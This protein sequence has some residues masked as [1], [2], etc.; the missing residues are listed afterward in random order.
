MPRENKFNLQWLKSKNNKIKSTYLHLDKCNIGRSRALI[1]F[2]VP[3]MTSRRSQL[4]LIKDIKNYFAKRLQNLKVNIQYFSVIEL[5]LQKWNPHL[6]FQIWYEEENDGRIEKAYY[7]T[8]KQFSLAQKRC[9]YTQESKGILNP[10][11]SFNYIIKEFDNTILSDKD[12]LDLDLAR[13]KLKQ[14]E[15][16]N[17]QFF[18]R[19]R[20]LHPHLLYKKLKQKYKLEYMTV[21]KLMNGYAIRLTGLKLMKAR[22]NRNFPYVIFKGGAIQIDYIKIY[23]LALLTLFYMYSYIYLSSQKSIYYN[24]RNNSYFYK[25]INTY[26]R[27]IIKKTSNSPPFKIGQRFNSHFRN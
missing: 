20:L 19:S 5:G 27:R 7:K 18:S 3:T 15:A 6:H 14:G 10:T 2:T 11:S 9:E 22:Q 23:N 24:K 8:I 16:K 4:I 1:T 12:I 26:A 13:R 25:N 21:D 17:I